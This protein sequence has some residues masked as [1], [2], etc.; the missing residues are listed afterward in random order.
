M[1]VESASFSPNHGGGGG[2]FYMRRPQEQEEAENEEEENASE[3]ARAIASDGCRFQGLKRVRMN[4]HPVEDEALCHITQEV[5]QNLRVL[6]MGVLR[7]EQRYNLNS[8]VYGLT[9]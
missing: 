3:P 9:Q 4:E 6:T 2:M 8:C 7:L 5:R 1:P